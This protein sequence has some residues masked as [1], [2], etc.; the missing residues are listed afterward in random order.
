MI[1]DES[2]KQSHEKRI[3]L[4]NQQHHCF[5]LFFFSM[6]LKI[7]HSKR[8]VYANKKMRCDWINYDLWTDSQPSNKQWRKQLRISKCLLL[9]LSLIL[10]HSKITNHP[11]PLFKIPIQLLLAISTPRKWSVS[12]YFRDFQ[13]NLNSGRTWYWNEQCV[14][15][16]IMPELVAC[17]CVFVCLSL[18]YFFSTFF[19]FCFAL[20]TRL[21]SLLKPC[22]T[23]VNIDIMNY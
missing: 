20:L 15:K 17:A 8:D 10:I 4:Q 22:D 21:I 16:W 23:C 6:L 18:L 19:M 9:V 7:A 11:P 14:N 12:F 3:N 1:R 2:A 5:V 13:S